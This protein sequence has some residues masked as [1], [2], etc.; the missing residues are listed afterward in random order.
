MVRAVKLTSK[1]RGIGCHEENCH[2]GEDCADF[3]FEMESRLIEM[4]LLLLIGSGKAMKMMVPKLR[5]FIALYILSISTGK[6]IWSLLRLCVSLTVSPHLS[7][8]PHSC[9]NQTQISLL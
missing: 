4:I 9:P 6:G 7:R 1:W 5:R 3:H 8:Y 2:A